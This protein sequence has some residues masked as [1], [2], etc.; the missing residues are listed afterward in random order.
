MITI[1]YST[2]KTNPEFQPYTGD[3][4]HVENVLKVSREDGQAENIKFV[5]RFQR[6]SMSINTNFN[7]NPYYDDYDEDKKFLRMLFKPGYAVQARELTQLQTILQKQ[8]E[9]FGNHIFQNGSVVTGGQTFL[10]DVTY[11]KLDST[12][13]TYSVTANNFVGATIVDSITNTTKRAQVIRVY[14]AD[15]GTGD[16]K[17]LLVKQLYGDAF[18]SGD[19]I[20]T[21]EAA[22]TSTGLQPGTGPPAAAHADLR[23]SDHDGD[24]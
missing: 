4:V 11:L 18:A 19:T 6:N 17:T 14:D 13:N 23:R 3:I 20:L 10:Q 5:V 8:V 1:G 24:A 15:A 2:R 16:P 22:P 9:R 21:D 7:A 12:Y